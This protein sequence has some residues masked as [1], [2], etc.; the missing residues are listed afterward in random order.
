MDRYVRPRWGR[1]L[2]DCFEQSGLTRND[3]V[4][5]LASDALND[6][7][8]P[9]ARVSAWLAEK[10]TVS[11][12]KAFEV[13][14]VLASDLRVRYTS[15]PAALYAAGY[16]EALVRLFESMALLGQEEYL[17][18]TSLPAA[19]AH[20]QRVSKYAVAQSYWDDGSAFDQ[21]ALRLYCLLPTAFHQFDFDSKILPGVIYPPNTIITADFERDWASPAR[22]ELLLDRFDLQQ[23]QEGWNKIGLHSRASRN[24]DATFDAACG[25]LSV[26]FPDPAEAARIAWSILKHRLRS[27]APITFKRYES[28][29]NAYDR[30][31]QERYEGVSYDV[32]VNQIPLLTRRNARRKSAER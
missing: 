3:L 18:R 6:D 22:Q 8:R 19:A 27:T 9:R 2:R 7:S 15:G 17:R 26:S 30:Y 20:A 31:V 32:P 21:T 1:W 10:S 14:Q 11:A 25:V 16:F 5:A 29:L 13:G 23:C 12:G 28:Y 24:L 4:L